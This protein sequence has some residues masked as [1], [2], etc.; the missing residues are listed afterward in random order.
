M[1]NVMDRQTAFNSKIIFATIYR[2]LLVG[3]IIALTTGCQSSDNFAGRQPV[4]EPTPYT[5]ASTNQTAYPANPQAQ[6]PQANYKFSPRNQQQQPNYYQAPNNNNDQRTYPNYQ[7]ARQL[8]TN[9]QNT[10]QPNQDQSYNPNPYTGYPQQN[11][12]QNTTPANNYPSQSN[13][14]YQQISANPPVPNQANYPAGNAPNSNEISWQQVPRR[15]ANVGQ[16]NHLSRP[17]QK[18]VVSDVSIVQANAPQ[19][20]LPNNQ[21]PGNFN[22]T[23]SNNFSTPQNFNQNSALPQ[24]PNDSSIQTVSP[25]SQILTV[26]PANQTP[27]AE[28]TQPALSV[29]NISAPISQ[30]NIS[31][32]LAALKLFVATHPEN[33]DAALALH[34]LYRSQNHN[35]QALLSLPQTTEQ[36][37]QALK[38]ITE[39]G[40]T[41]AD[42]A[43]LAIV[44]FKICDQV[45]G[46][47]QYQETAPH[48]LSIS[49]EREIQIY[50][51]V[52]NYKS[53][54]NSQGNFYTDLHAEVSLFD[55]NY[56][57]LARLSADVPDKPTAKP[58]RD[59][60]LSG[61]L[62]IPALSPGKYQ[63]TIRMTDKAAQKIA[64]PCHIFFEVKPNSQSLSSP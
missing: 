7:A 63:I 21:P 6:P 43:D 30:N 2:F 24:N 23:N 9:Q 11:N 52:Q 12:I 46:F 16:T 40:S 38:T 19:Q 4:A 47:G 57:I 33:T 1:K 64:R 32:T 55:E 17:N 60:F 61:P 13:Q 53:I 25:S 50:C 44:D 51:E 39:L 14:Q 54:Q 8:N 18:P 37:N 29:Q 41:I 42:K 15:P 10:Y 48:L 49:Q 45:L 20:N 27:P 34:Y 35:D 28:L 62:R 5:T 36:A 22:T 59:F 3:L 31:E 26:P 58:R 56:Q